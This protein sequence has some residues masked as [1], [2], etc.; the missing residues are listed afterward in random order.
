MK[1]SQTI[2]EVIR[3]ATAIREYWDAELPKR[4]AKYP[5]ISPGEDSGPPP[6]ESV[7]L[8][9][10]LEHLSEDDFCRLELIMHLGRGD[11]GV[12]ELSTRFAEIQRRFPKSDSS[13]RQV[14]GQSLVDEDLSEGLQA[15]NKFGVDVD[16]LGNVPLPA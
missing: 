1:F 4:H 16:H 6:A 15:L 3:L 2:A 12:E 14:L 5:L 9:Q 8:F 13:D 11:F 10:L 7:Q